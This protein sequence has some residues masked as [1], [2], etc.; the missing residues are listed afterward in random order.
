MEQTDEPVLVPTADLKQLDASLDNFFK[1][2]QRA[3]QSNNFFKN[4]A[5]GFS[6]AFGLVFLPKKINNEKLNFIMN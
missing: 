2:Q 1:D 6:A 5:N 4:I 3:P